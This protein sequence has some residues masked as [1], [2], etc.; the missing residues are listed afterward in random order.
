LY[1]VFKKIKVDKNLECSERITPEMVNDVEFLSILLRRLKN[2]TVSPKKKI[3]S[4][5]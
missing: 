1:L 5:F 2:K 4:N 3:I